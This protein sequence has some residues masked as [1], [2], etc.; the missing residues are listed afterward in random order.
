MHPTIDDVFEVCE[1]KQLMHCFSL[2]KFLYGETNNKK[3]LYILSYQMG[4][5]DKMYMDIT[6]NPII[7]QCMLKIDYIA[8]EMNCIQ[9]VYYEKCLRIPVNKNTQD[10]ANKYNHENEIKTLK[11]TNAKN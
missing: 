11:I 4:N 5:I 7:I 8:I 10:R 2:V 9:A 1:T 3:L 6:Y